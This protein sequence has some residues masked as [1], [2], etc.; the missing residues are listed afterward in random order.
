MET[1]SFEQVLKTIQANVHLLLS[2]PNKDKGEQA[3]W[4]KFTTGS[5]SLYKGFGNHAD[6]FSPGPLEKNAGIIRE[7]LKAID[8]RLKKKNPK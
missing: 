5:F 6:M 3:G 7:I 2:G 1:I 4:D 8:N